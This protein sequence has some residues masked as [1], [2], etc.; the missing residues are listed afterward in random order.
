MVLA[1]RLFFHHDEPSGKSIVVNG[2]SGAFDLLPTAL[3]RKLEAYRGREM[4]GEEWGPLA[5][6]VETLRQR[7]YLFESGEEEESTL[8]EVRRRVEEAVPPLTKFVICPTYLCNL[9]CSYC[10]EGDLTRRPGVMSK[11]L[12]QAA[13]A[14]I[15]V[16]KRRPEVKRYLHELFGG[17]PL[18]P[19]TRSVV[20][21]LLAALEKQGDT[22]AIVTNGTHVEEF[23]PLLRK[24]HAAVESLQITIDGP[25]AVH[26]QRRVFRDGSGSFER[27]ARGVEQLLAEDF[28]VRLR[29]NVDRRNLGNVSELLE[30]IERRDWSMYRHFSCGVAPVTHHTQLIR[31]DDAMS[32]GEIIRVIQRDCPALLRNQPTCNLGVFRVLN[33]ALSVLEGRG[34]GTRVLPSFTYCEAAEGSVYVFGPDG[35]IY[36]CPDSIID[37]KWGVGEFWPQFRLD[38][39]RIQVWRR[40]IFSIPE[41]RDC[42]I[43]TFCGGGCALVQMDRGL[44]HPF[45][46]GAR[47]SLDEYLSA[48]F[49]R[50]SRGA[51]PPM[52]N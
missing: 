19:A 18:L 10:Y 17:E 12:L 16:L 41:C 51:A 40:D 7:G 25:K 1:K 50:R 2:V 15:D 33:H 3:A 6:E 4:A 44:S 48:W 32:E 30:F 23:M 42:E 22:V 34:A 14:A 24:H 31:Y 38:E 8:R 36:A 11:E 21:D 45:C 5:G 49:A 47:E 27:I 37:C 43:A 9:A 39:D 29:V 13:L 46:N 35:I 28:V 52:A 20:A 26:D